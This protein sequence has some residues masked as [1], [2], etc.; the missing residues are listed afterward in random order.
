MTCVF[1][2]FSVAK[3]VVGSPYRVNAS[4]LMPTRRWL[5]VLTCVFFCAAVAAD[6]ARPAAAMTTVASR[7]IRLDTK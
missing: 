3:A 5:D 4:S 7:A 2:D 1:S 6:T